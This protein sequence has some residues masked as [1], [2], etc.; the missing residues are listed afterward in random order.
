VNH[1]CEVGS[2]AETLILIILIYVDFERVGKYN[3]IC[4]VLLASGKNTDK[5]NDARILS[6]DLLKKRNLL[7]ALLVS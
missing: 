1:L 7:L 2:C 3:L 4:A 5:S 6:R